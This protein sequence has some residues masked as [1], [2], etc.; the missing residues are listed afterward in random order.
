MSYVTDE[1]LNTWLDSWARWVN[2]GSCIA[3][4]DYK[5]QSIDQTFIQSNQSNATYIKSYEIEE[6]IDS[7]VGRLAIDKRLAADVGRFEYGAIY[8]S[9]NPNYDRPPTIEIKA[10]RLTAYL[11]KKGVLSPGKQINSASY[12]R[13]LGIF[14]DW[15]TA[16]MS[17]R[18]SMVA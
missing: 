5:P 13:Q 15:M 14:R 12:K 10:A 7:A 1:Q 6:S 9:Y 16:S 3:N 18:M 8:A 11:L 17:M 2:A 4:L